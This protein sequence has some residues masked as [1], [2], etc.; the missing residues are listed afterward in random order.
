MLIVR[1]IPRKEPRIVFQAVQLD[2]LH[3]FNRRQGQSYQRFL[4][5]AQRVG[6]FSVNSHSFFCYFY[7]HGGKDVVGVIKAELF[8]LPLP[9]NGFEHVEELDAEGVL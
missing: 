7:V 1:V 9:K 8:K 3:V 6:F 5:K 4:D 2:P